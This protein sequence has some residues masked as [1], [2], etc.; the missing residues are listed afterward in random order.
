MSGIRKVEVFSAGCPLC[1]EAINKVRELACPSCDV[2]VMNMKEPAAMERARQLGV[3]S[4][5]AV[6]I[7]GK[8]ADC[9]KGRGI[10]IETLLGAG[11][12]K[13]LSSNW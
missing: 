3:Q 13:P 11:L 12:G 7:G 4:V 1:D 10:N 9:C 8:L 6:A 2:T 5:P